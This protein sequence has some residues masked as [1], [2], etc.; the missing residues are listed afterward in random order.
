MRKLHEY[1]ILLFA[2]S[3][4]IF[5]APKH[6][7]FGMMAFGFMGMLLCDKSI[8][9]GKPTLIEWL[10]M[11]IL[12]TSAI[13]TFLNWPRIE[14]IKGVKYVFYYSSTFWMLYRNRYSPS[15]LRK[16]PMA[17]VAG[18][19]AGIFMAAY[20]LL[21]TPSPSPVPGEFE[22]KFNSINSVSRSGAFSA[23]I[24]FVCASVLMDSVCGFKRRT[25]LFSA[26]SWIIISACVLIMGGRGNA[27]GVFGAY[28]IL[29]IPLFR[30]KKYF[31]FITIQGAIALIAVMVLLSFGTTLQG[32]FQHLLSTKFTAN[33]SDLGL[34]DQMRY[35]YWRIGVAQ[36]SQHPSLFGVGPQNFKSIKVKNLHLS[37]PLLKETLDLIDGAPQHAH[38]WLLTKGVEDGMVGG[39][40]FVSLMVALFYGLW[41]RRPVHGQDG[42]SW[43]WM[44]AFSALLIAVISG[45]FNS[46]FTHE[47]GWLT[48]FLMG[49]GAGTCTGT[50]EGEKA[51][52]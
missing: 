34:H 16:I 8:R 18:T 22:L 43:M 29:W 52:C 50:Q 7:G 36:I 21:Y 13:S 37:P 24:L 28:L 41:K 15:F 38:N 30:Y 12:L 5:E 33:I 2:F 25:T 26:L 42:I 9:P 51:P 45:F 23:T 11:A 17:L 49:L 1:G 40:L 35:D 10:L 4:P 20:A 44:A 47:N 48:Y 3:L 32:R 6:V 14:E 39:A 46:A 31:K 27:V 19:L